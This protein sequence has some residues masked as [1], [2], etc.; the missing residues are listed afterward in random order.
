MDHAKARPPESPQLR[1]FVRSIWTYSSNEPRRFEL[2][3]PGGG[4]QLIINLFEDELRH[5]ASPEI[6]CRRIGPVG[7]QGAL[8]RP[9]VIDT[10][11]KRDVCG[12]AFHHGGLSPLH[13]QP[14]KYFIDALVDGVTMLGRAATMLREELRRMTDADERMCLIEAFL[15]QH[16]RSRPEEDELVRRVATALAQGASISELRV[17]LGLSQRRLHNL[18]DRRI[19]IRPKLFARIERFAASLDAMPDRLCWSD[20]A[21]AHGFADQAHFIRE[22]QKLSGYLPTQYVSLPDE[23]RHARPP[24]DKIFNT[25]RTV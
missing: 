15:I 5:W 17:R 23:T 13:N 10:H 8:T 2:V 22:F 1:P 4:G 19:G 9:V 18:F 3:M 25:K 14:A 7:L 16:L 6:V 24:P 20:L 21:F 12:V 11:Q